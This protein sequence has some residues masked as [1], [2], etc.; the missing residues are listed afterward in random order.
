M[1]R[2]DLFNLGLKAAFRIADCILSIAKPKRFDMT[3]EEMWSCYSGL[4]PEKCS[5]ILHFIDYLEFERKEKNSKNQSARRYGGSA[6]LRI[7]GILM[8]E[9]R[10]QQVFETGV[11]MGASSAL[12]LWLLDRWSTGMGQVVSSDLYYADSTISI[13]PHDCLFQAA[14]KKFKLSGS[15]TLLMQG[16]FRN[17]WAL[18]SSNHQFDFISYDSDKTFLGRCTAIFL[19]HF[20]GLVTRESLLVMDDVNNNFAFHFIA[21][22]LRLETLVLWDE[23]GCKLVGVA[24]ARLPAFKGVHQ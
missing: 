22:V 12:L 2:G 3:V 1:M 17:I 6:C 21:K 13:D 20:K 23:S 7:L 5:Q 4:D 9:R 18:D 8:L 19:L 14:T 24:A 15:R 16:D 11:A 10:P